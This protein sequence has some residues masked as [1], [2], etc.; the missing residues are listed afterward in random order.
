MAITLSTPQAWTNTAGSWKQA[1]AEVTIN[2]YATGGVG[3]SLSTLGLSTL[4]YIGFGSTKG[5]YAFEYDYDNNKIKVYAIKVYHDASPGDAIAI[6]ADGSRI[7]GNLTGTADLDMVLEEIENS[8]DL[9]G[10]T[11]RIFAVGLA[12]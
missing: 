3:L 10:V 7:E 2:T 12:S 8:A 9:S 1:I 5:G 11:V 4:Y 6:A